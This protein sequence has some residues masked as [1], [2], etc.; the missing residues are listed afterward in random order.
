VKRPTPGWSAVVTVTTSGRRDLARWVG[1][2]LA[3]EAL[4]E[5]ARAEATIRSRGPG[6]LE[7]TIR[8]ADA[9]A[10]RAALNTYLGW[11][12]LSLATAQAAEPGRRRPGG[13]P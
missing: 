13:A 7:L 4:R 1:R 2:A 11:I 8:A 9:G 5:L 12:Q 6:R 10:M 3:P